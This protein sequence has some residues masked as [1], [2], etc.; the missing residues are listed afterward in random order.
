MHTNTNGSSTDPLHGKGQ[1]RPDRDEIRVR[2]FAPRTVNPKNF[3]WPMSLTVG[4]AADEAAAAF[5]YEAG[6]PTFQ[7]EQDEVLDRQKTLEAAGV[8]DKDEL[9]LTDTGGGV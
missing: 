8:E 3:R 1:H 2:V 7:N 4:E 5:E 6:N 9:T